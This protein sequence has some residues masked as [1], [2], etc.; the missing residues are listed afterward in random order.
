MLYCQHALGSD[1]D[2]NAC[3]AKVSGARVRTSMVPCSSKVQVSHLLSILDQEA[4]G[5]EVMACP[6]ESCGLLVGSHRAARRVEY[7]R[8]LLDRIGVGQERL[9]I[10]HG[11]ELPAEEFARRVAARAEAVMNLE[12][13]GDDQ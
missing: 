10:S 13:D 4:E 6:L 9:G 12:K 2:A 7:A 3:A 8:S 1:V 5:V 11:V